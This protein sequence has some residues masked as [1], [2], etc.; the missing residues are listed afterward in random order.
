MVDEHVPGHA[1]VGVAVA[2]DRAEP[3]GG[4]AAG[5]GRLLVRARDEQRGGEQEDGEGG[6]QVH[7]AQRGQRALLGRPL[8]TQREGG[9]RGGDRQQQHEHDRSLGL[10]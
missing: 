2:L 8:S 9:G 3:G 7:A 4:G 5:E 10:A 6:E 1:P